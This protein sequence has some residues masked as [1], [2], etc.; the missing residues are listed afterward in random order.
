MTGPLALG[1]VPADVAQPS[2]FATAPAALGLALALVPRDRAATPQARLAACLDIH[3]ASP[4]FLP[5]P[6]RIVLTAEAARARVAQAAPELS[7][8]LAASADRAELTL[9]V[10]FADG[11]NVCATAD[12]RA[13]LARRAEARREIEQ[14]REATEAWLTTLARALEAE[15]APPHAGPSGIRA[16]LS[17]LRLPAD[18]LGARLSEAVRALGPPPSGMGRAIATGPWP[19]FSFCEIGDPT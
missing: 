13:W 4:A 19:L 5:W 15:M 8:L 18:R 11:G 17:L 1:I 10:P 6:P 12:G 14:R 3:E 2:A 16:A 9:T 7:C